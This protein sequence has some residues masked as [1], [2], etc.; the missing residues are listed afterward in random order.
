ML[1]DS[2][3]TMPPRLARTHVAPLNVVN[4]MAWMFQIKGEYNRPN[5][6]LVRTVEAVQNLLT[7]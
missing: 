4:G 2:P 3:R 7:L 6:H 5:F 1:P